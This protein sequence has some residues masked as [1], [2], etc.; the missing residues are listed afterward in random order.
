MGKLHQIKRVF[1]KLDHDTKIGMYT[2]KPPLRYGCIQKDLWGKAGIR[3]PDSLWCFYRGMPSYRS[4]VTKLVSN[5]YRTHVIRQ[6]HVVE[7][8]YLNG[9]EW[10]I[11]I[12]TDSFEQG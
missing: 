11:K 4:Y 12:I 9:E 10:A 1:N 5:Y 6:R 2:N 7:R 3:V 8:A